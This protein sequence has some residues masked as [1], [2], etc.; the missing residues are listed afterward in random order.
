MKRLCGSIAF[1]LVAGTSALAADMPVKAPPPPPPPP[2]F[3]WTGFYIGG[4]VG[5]SWGRASTD[6][7]ETQTNTATIST[8][9][10]TQIASASATTNFFGNERADLNG[11]LGGFQAGY[12]LQFDRVVAGLE[13]DIQWTDERGGVTSVRW[14]SACRP[15]RASRQR[16]PRLASRTI[17]F[18]GLQPCAAG[19]A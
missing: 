10:G 4:N 17:V 13:G 2:V 8:L 18:R 5:Y 6:I 12:N 11:W 9:A 14:P 19:S 16:G 7:V 15:D 1:V 3:T